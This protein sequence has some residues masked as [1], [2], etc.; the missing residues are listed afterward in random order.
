MGAYGSIRATLAHLIG[1]E[2]DYANRVTGK[3]LPAWMSGDQWPGFEALKDTV[4]GAGEDLA[5]L[6][7]SARADSIVRETLPEEGV[8]VQYPL[9]DLLVQAINH[10]TEHR[11]QV[12]AII[13]QLGVEPPVMD[14]WTYM[15]EKGEFREERLGSGAG[16]DK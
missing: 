7:V 14:G 12:S 16:E 1:A 2:A 9:R 8:I 5:Q 6:A 13:T 3:T 15:E 4:R 10:S 11:T